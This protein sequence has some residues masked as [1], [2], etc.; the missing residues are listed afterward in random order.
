[1]LRVAPIVAAFI[2]RVAIGGC[3]RAG[4]RVLGL[5]E[6]RAGRKTGYGY[7]VANQPSGRV[8]I[9]TS[10]V[11]VVVSAASAAWT[12]DNWRR[13]F[14]FLCVFVF[15]FARLFVRSFVC[16]HHVRKGQFNVGALYAQF[17]IHLHLYRSP[18]ASKENAKEMTSRSGLRRRRIEGWSVYRCMKCVSLAVVGCRWSSTGMRM[19]WL[20]PGRCGF[21]CVPFAVANFRHTNQPTYATHLSEQTAAHTSRWM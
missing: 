3:V 10:V 13:L 5:L 12:I 20:G 18:F 1:M 8:C 2:C 15:V 9:F 6:L 17:R 16:L 4:A 7:L 11:I 14:F 21:E 19:G